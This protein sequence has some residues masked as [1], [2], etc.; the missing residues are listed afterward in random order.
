M[1]LHLTLTFTFQSAFKT[2][3]FIQQIKLKP[4]TT[5][6]WHSI[7][8][9]SAVIFKSSLL[10][11]KLETRIPCNV[12]AVFCQ[13]SMEKREMSFMSIIKNIDISLVIHL[14][15]FKPELFSAA[16]SE[17]A[18]QDTVQLAA[19]PTIPEKEEWRSKNFTLSFNDNYNHGHPQLKV[20]RPNLAFILRW[21]ICLSPH[22]SMRR[23]E[24]GL[25]T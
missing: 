21:F 15:R 10:H 16:L 22:V 5:Q 23:E 8:L 4:E 7:L 25:F 9:S 18:T 14:C 12:S 19:I 2:E 24:Q 1:F 20:L 3:L 17:F 6:C 13:P 11:V